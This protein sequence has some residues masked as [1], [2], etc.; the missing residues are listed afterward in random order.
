M[1][2]KVF[3]SW[4]GGKDS[5]LSLLKAKEMGLDVHTLV[6]F[7]NSEE[8]SMSHGLSRELLQEQATALGIPLEVEMV[9]WEDYENG[10]MRVTDRIKEKGIT[11]GVFGDINLKEHREWVEKMCER[12]ALSP[13]LP[14]WG[15]GEDEVIFELLDRGARL[16]VVSVRGDLINEEWLGKEVDME[17]YQMCESQGISPCGE[18]G[19]Y[20][21]LAAGGPLFKAPLRFDTGEIFKVKE[22]V[23]LKITPA[24]P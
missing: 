24:L 3:V 15:M 1:E 2:Q 9:T 20:H 8:R 4:S 21:T 13:Y 19:E 14:L 7:M 17:F 22:W 6:T 10:F 23:F 18:N 5:Y 16:V 12:A 11:G